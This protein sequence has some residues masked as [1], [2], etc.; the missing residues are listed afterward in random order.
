MGDTEEKEKHMRR[1]K[2]N[3]IARDL[4]DPKG[5]FAMKVI[6]PKKEKYRRIKINVKEVNS[7]DEDNE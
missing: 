5:P 6:N 4:R 2:R 3:I 1:R 7:L